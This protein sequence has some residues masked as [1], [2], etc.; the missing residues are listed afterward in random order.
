[1]PAD[2]INKSGRNLN[3]GDIVDGR[4][5]VSLCQKFNGLWEVVAAGGY[6]SNRNRSVL[7]RAAKIPNGWSA[8]RLP[9]GTAA[10][11]YRDGSDTLNLVLARR[12]AELVL[13]G[14]HELMKFIAGGMIAH[15]AVCRAGGVPPVRCDDW[16]LNVDFFAGLPA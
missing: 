7:V 14:D 11:R 6:D 1:M 16:I 3:C 12:T 4:Q 8:A 15:M 13:S 10:I 2:A 5:L 9:N